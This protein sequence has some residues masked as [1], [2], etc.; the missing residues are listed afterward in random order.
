[1][2]REWTL[3]GLGMLRT[4]LDEE[5]VYRLHIWSPAHAVENVSGLHTHPWDFRSTV[6]VGSVN[7]V[8]FMRT[9]NA[10]LDAEGVL[11]MQQLRIK[12]GEGACSVSDPER[13]RL[14]RRP[15]I[16]WKEGES[17]FE[18]AE[19]IHLSV[20]ENGTVTIIERTFGQDVDHAYIFYPSGEQWVSAEPRKATPQEV[21]DICE[22]ALRKWF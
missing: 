20:P 19:E 18:R 3:Q 12:C 15:S 7:N 9:P 2:D 10:S 16:R 8:L 13:V 11:D 22:L 1:M 5:R 21:R 4:Y 6:I 14:M 17:Y